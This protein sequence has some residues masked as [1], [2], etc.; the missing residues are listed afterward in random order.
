MIGF[1]VV[2]IFLF[3]PKVMAI[4]L[5]ALLTNSFS[6]VNEGK[7]CFSTIFNNVGSL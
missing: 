1:G 6:V 5:M 2:Q 7:Q 4:K 3:L